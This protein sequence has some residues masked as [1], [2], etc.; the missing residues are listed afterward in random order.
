MCDFCNYEEERPKIGCSLTIVDENGDITTIEKNE[1]KYY[2]HELCQY[3]QWFKSL[4]HAMGYEWIDEVKIV[5]HSKG[6]FEDGDKEFSSE[7][8]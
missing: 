3:A 7:D 4:I 8:F 5:S 2:D 1:F 6:D